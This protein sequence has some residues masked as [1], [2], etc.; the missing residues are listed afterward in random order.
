MDVLYLKL[1]SGEHIISFVDTIDNEYVV[2]DKPLQL[3]VQNSVKGAAVRV[4][5]WIPFIEDHLLS[6]KQNHILMYSKPTQDIEDCY[7]EAINALSD[8]EESIGLANE[9]RDIEEEEVTMALYEKFSNT[10][11]V[12]H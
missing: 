8:E 3:F 12:V 9:E 4:A 7:F 6:V 11:I 10:S 5:K 2:L 1:V